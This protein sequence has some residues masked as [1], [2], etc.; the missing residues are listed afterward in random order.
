MFA[1]FPPGC[2]VPSGQSSVATVMADASG[3][4]Y[5][6]YNTTLYLS[7]NGVKHVGEVCSV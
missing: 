1:L 3:L 7:T 2:N 4:A 6:T 5:G